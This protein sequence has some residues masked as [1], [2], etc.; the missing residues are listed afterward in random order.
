MR[1]AFAAVL[2]SLLAAFAAAVY[3]ATEG[4]VTDIIRGCEN[5]QCYPVTAECAI[6][7][8]SGKDACF[9][10]CHGEMSA[11]FNNCEIAQQG[12]A[13]ACAGGHIDCIKGCLTT[14][15]LGACVPVY[16]IANE[17]VFIGCVLS[18]EPGP[19]PGATP[20]PAASATRTPTPYQAATPA[21]DVP[22]GN[23]CPLGFALAGLGLAAMLFTRKK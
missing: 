22:P 18:N 14:E 3:P 13:D 5:N 16:N 7:C 12:C 2:F 6:A 8:D 23:G 19:T 17:G 4:A 10:D 11:C 20:T 21:S 9:A 1:I 15:G